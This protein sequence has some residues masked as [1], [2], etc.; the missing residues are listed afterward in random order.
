MSGYMIAE[1]WCDDCDTRVVAEDEGSLR[2]LRASLREEGWVRRRP[3]RRRPD[4]GDRLIDLC[5]PCSA[6]GRSPE[7]ER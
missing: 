3:E 1:V 4:T 5:E 6:S 2:D 7:E